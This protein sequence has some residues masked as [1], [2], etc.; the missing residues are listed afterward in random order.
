MPK[1]M[2][3]TQR[4]AQ[5]TK[6]Q[7]EVRP[8]D[9]SL[10]FLLASDPT[11]SKFDVLLP[12]LETPFAKDVALVMIGR[13]AQVDNSRRLEAEKVAAEFR[14]RTEAAHARRSASVGI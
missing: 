8:G 11:P 3:G 13:V 4:A 6:E 10:L 9:A 12:Y 1:Q 7:P 5:K 14:A 2:S